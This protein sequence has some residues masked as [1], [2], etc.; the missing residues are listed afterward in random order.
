MPLLTWSSKYS[1][2]VKELDEQHTQFIGIINELHAAMLKGQAQ[3]I[4]GVP[5]PKLMNYA[6]NHFATEERLM[7]RTK[8]PGLAEHRAEHLKMIGHVEDFVARHKRGDTTM[9]LELLQF[10]RDWQTDHMMQVDKKYT[11][12]LNEH[13]VR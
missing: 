10:V 9:Y 5:N 3:S 13:G 8:F 6:T 2:G 12:W 7:E 4:A 11:L 1:V